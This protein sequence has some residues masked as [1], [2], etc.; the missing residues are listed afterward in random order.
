MR[1]RY[2]A[3]VMKHEGYLLE[4][5][6][7]GQRPANL[8]L[9][10]SQQGIKWLG[11]QIRSTLNGEAGDLQGEVEFVAR[12]KLDGRACVLHERSRFVHEQDRWFYLDGDM[13]DE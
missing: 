5:W 2:V 7:P 9:T 4:T 10:T 11:L 8:D 12:Y 3:F 13:L 1:S 6:H